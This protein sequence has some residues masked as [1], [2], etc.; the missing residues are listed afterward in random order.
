MPDPAAGS[1][2]SASLPRRV[3]ISLRSFYLLAREPPL[4]PCAG[5]NGVE[6]GRGRVEPQRSGGP[7][8]QD[9]IV[10]EADR[11][12]SAGGD[13]RFAQ[14]ACPGRRGGERAFGDHR[15]V[16]RQRRPA[17]HA[18]GVRNLIR[19]GAVGRARLLPDH[20]ERDAAGESA[21][22]RPR[23]QD[24]LR[25]RAVDL[26]RRVGPVRARACSRRLDRVSNRP[27]VG[28]SDD[29]RAGAVDPGRRLPQ[30]R[31]RDGAGLSSGPLSR[32]VSS[33]A[34]CWAAS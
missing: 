8:R 30:G 5:E 20:G 28:R 7:R 3:E 16:D 15:R 1:P 6:H 33:S 10:R 29:A 27:G 32:S 24:D 4:C 17:H 13:R 25:R 14:V 19:G 31:A 21:R 26:Y 22:R 18:R 2:G 12:A 23:S 34:R 11:R 9:G